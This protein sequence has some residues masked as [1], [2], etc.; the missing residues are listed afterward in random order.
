MGPS[1]SL[2]LPI[3]SRTHR[4]P[5]LR[6]SKIIAWLLHIRSLGNLGNTTYPNFHQK[7][8]LKL[9]IYK[10][11]QQLGEIFQSEVDAYKAIHPTISHDL[12]NTFTS[13]WRLPSEGLGVGLLS[14]AVAHKMN[15]QFSFRAGFLLLPVVAQLLWRSTQ[16]ESYFRAL[17]FMDFTLEAR[18]AKGAMELQPFKESKWLI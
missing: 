3:L 4:R 5:H 14:Q 1:L 2:K 13:K 11:K 16:V 17:E 15:L 10:K 8:L 9:A 6:S 7:P 18:K 12:N